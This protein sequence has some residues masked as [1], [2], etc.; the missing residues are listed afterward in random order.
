MFSNI[1][2][3][4]MITVLRL[5][6]RKARDKRVTTHVG[7]VARAFGANELLI[8][9]KDENIENT[10]KDVAARFGGNFS[11]KSGIKWRGVLKKWNGIA[12][13]LTMYGEHLDDII[14]TIPKDKNVLV[15]V[16][17]EKV[18]GEI[19]GLVDF[20]IAVGNQ[21]HSEVAALAVFMDRFLEGEG[22][23]KDFDGKMKV[24]PSKRGKRVVE[25]HE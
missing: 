12:V 23:R 6:H 5:G 11:V 8:S 9:T 7:L 19:Y 15:I 16:G 17:A 13:H 14:E 3:I 18:P 25:Q 24:L 2:C 21:P 22:L 20:N 4:H 1:W 10:L